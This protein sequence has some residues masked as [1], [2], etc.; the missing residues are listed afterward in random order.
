MLPL[1]G[2]EIWLGVLP[3]LHSVVAKTGCRSF[4]SENVAIRGSFR[5][6]VVEYFIWATLKFRKNENEKRKKY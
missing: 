5:G 6:Y 4:L 2:Q 1:V 3:A